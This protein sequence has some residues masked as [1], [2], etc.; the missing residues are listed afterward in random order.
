MD[1]WYVVFV[2]VM[3]LKWTESFQCNTNHNKS[4][5]IA[6][7]HIKGELSYTANTPALPYRSLSSR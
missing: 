2:L 7:C 3:V 1:G 4:V 6:H 5:I